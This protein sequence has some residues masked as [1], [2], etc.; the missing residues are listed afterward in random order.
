MA[1]GK[2]TGCLHRLGLVQ[3]PERRGSLGHLPLSMHP[4]YRVHGVP[5]NLWS[6]TRGFCGAAQQLVTDPQ[7][8]AGQPPT[9]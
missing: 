1:S 9:N 3:G 8:S 2:T 4:L 5:L 7:W 6:E